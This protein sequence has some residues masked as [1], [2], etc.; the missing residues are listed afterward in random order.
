MTNRERFFAALAKKQPDKTPYNVL[1]TKLARKNMAAWY[2]D[3]DFERKI[4]NCF[5]VVDFDGFDH[6]REI[7]PNIFEDWFGVQW[8]RTIDED[9]GVVSPIPT[10][11][12]FTR[13]RRRSS[14][15]LET[16][17]SSETSASAPSSAPGLSWA[18]N[19]CW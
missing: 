6:C 13:A 7:R 5:T 11:R 17:S 15:P 4:G 2:H 12:S 16:R 19:S 3:P 9:I 14:A 1:L 8:D 18:W 10:A